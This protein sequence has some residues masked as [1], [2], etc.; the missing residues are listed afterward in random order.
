MSVQS[1]QTSAPSPRGTQIIV[2]LLVIIALL[3]AVI[4][5]LILTRP[6]GGASAG[7]AQPSASSVP[8]ATASAAAPSESPTPTAPVTAAPSETDPQVLDILHG[9]VTRD[10][11]DPRARGE[12][13]APVV[14]V[15]YSDFACPYCTQFAQEVEPALAD[16]VADGT[17]RIEW[18]D[19]AQISATSPL[20]A[21]A[22]IAAGNQGRFWEFHDAV[23]AAANPN[24]HPEYTEDSLVAFA[25]QAGVV[26][27]DRFR[28]D[29]LAQSTVETVTS[30]TQHAY[31]IG[32]TGTPFIIINDAYIAGYVPAE[33]V[34]ATI[35]DQ[36]AQ[37]G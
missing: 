27:L 35:L 23:Y 19:L 14:M 34:R 37:A 2:V 10:P 29:M 9:E 1:A 5:G 11:A 4:A 15:L 22:G 12:A 24:E 26:D 8:P 13:D 28:S 32:V 30:A 6:Q 17:L 25:E 3:L 20:A 33:F 7:A 21:Q 16:L 36:A 18:R 31:S